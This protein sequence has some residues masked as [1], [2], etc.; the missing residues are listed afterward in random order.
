MVSTESVSKSK[1][2]LNDDRELV[3]VSESSVNQKVPP[4]TTKE[5]LKKKMKRGYVPPRRVDGRTS[6]VPATS[7]KRYLGFKR[8]SQN[9]ILVSNSSLQKTACLFK[10]E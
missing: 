6:L 1:S 3:D 8:S 10:D 4:K 7:T 5:D 2:L 9:Q